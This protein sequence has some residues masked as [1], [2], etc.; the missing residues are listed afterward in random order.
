M[1]SSEL[2]AAALGVFQKHP[3][4]LTKDDQ[5]YWKAPSFMKEYPIADKVFAKKMK[6]AVAVLQACP[7]GWSG[8][9]ETKSF[10][11]VAKDWGFIRRRARWVCKEDVDIED[12]NDSNA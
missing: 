12:S 5:E 6:D 8:D 3:Q 1:M 9:T 10:A 7:S 11:D 2:S 4:L